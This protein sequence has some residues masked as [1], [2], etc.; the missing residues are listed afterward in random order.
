MHRRDRGALGVSGLVKLVVIVGVLGAL[1]YDAFVT[2]ATHLKAE[3][4]AQNA[5]FAASNAWFNSSGTGRS[6]ATAFQAA[7]SYV[8]A[9]DPQDHVCGT[10]NETADPAC[11]GVTDTACGASAYTFCVA[12][13]GTVHLV[14]RREAKTLIFRHF[15]FMHHL[16]VAYEHGDANQDQG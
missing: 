4:D 16:L 8:A 9:N 7:V 3:N 15:G 5:A 11:P 6:Y 10:M 14:L 1:G 13:D 2:I 12:P